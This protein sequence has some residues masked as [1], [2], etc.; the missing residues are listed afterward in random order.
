MTLPLIV[1]ANLILGFIIGFIAAFVVSTLLGLLYVWFYNKSQKTIA[2]R[3]CSG[4]NRS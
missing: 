4:H 2:D 3:N 1:D